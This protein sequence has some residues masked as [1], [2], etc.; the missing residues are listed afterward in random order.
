MDTAAH[1]LLF[2]RDPGAFAPAA[3]APDWLDPDWLARAPLVVRRAPAA[4]G[5]VAVGLRGRRRSE[6]CAGFADLSAVERRLRPEA[7]V[8][9]PGPVPSDGATP[10]LPCLA[11]LRDLAPRLAALGLAWGPAGGVGFWLA[12]GLPVLRPDSDLD[13][14]VRAPRPLP[15][16]VV[17]ALAALQGAYPCRIDIQVDTGEGGFALAELARGG[18]VLLKTAAGPLLLDD[19]WDHREPA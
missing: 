14:L 9:A 3:D 4:P 15:E 11:A 2:L 6:R 19:P 1:D 10:A 12:S 8:A 5:R 13:L 7:L 17:A 18:R 16:D